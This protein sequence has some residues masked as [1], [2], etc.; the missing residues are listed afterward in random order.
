MTVSN[1]TQ[2]PIPISALKAGFPGAAAGACQTASLMWISTTAA[3]QH[4]SGLSMSAAIRTL[5]SQG[6]FRRFYAGLAPTIAHVTLCR[7]A[8]TTSNA[9]ALRHAPL[10]GLAQRT[11]VASILSA[12]CRASLL[13]LETL[14]S[15]MQVRGARL[16]AGLVL[17][18]WYAAGLPALYTGAA[19][20]FT[21]GLVGHFPFFF[22]LNAVDQTMPISKETPIMHR[23]ARNGGL[24]FIAAMTSDVC[25]NGFKVI[26]TNMQT[27][28]KGMSYLDTAR[29][30]VMMDGI[31]SLVTRGLKTRLIG[32]GL[33]GATFVMLWK[34]IEVRLEKN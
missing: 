5:Y 16:G 32:T 15:N 1:R 30:I 24:G 14:R 29:K 13:P 34:E 8:D 22:T 2:S 21:A 6:G 23:F 17:S 25:T 31:F 12:A 7:F 18:K 10:D 4:R 26:A 11:A 33:K 28:T 19:A 9:L 20:S 27:C 3:Y